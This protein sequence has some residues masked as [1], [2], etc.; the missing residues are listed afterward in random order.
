MNQMFL[1]DTFQ[2][3]FGTGVVPDTFRIN[4]RYRS[5]Q[6]DAQAGGTGTKND[7]LGPGQ[8][9]FLEPAFEKIPRRLAGGAGTAFRII[10]CH[11]Q[12]NMP[13]DFMDA[14]SFRRR[15][16]IVQFVVHG[17][18]SFRRLL[19]QTLV[20]R[21]GWR[22][23]MLLF[24]LAGAGGGEAKADG[25]QFLEP[26]QQLAGLLRGQSLPVTFTVTNPTDQSITVQATAAACACTTLQQAPTNIPPHGLGQ[27]AWLYDSTG[28]TGAVSQTV[29][30][31]I[32]GGPVLT[33]LFSTEVRTTVPGGNFHVWPRPHG[34]YIHDPSTIVKCNNEH[35]LFSTG[36]GIP[37]HHSPT[38]TNWLSGP[39]VFL[40]PPAWTAQAVPGN[41]G[42]FWAP[43]IIHVGNR[44]LLY[45]AVSTW[46]KRVSAIGLATTPTL[47]P[48]DQRYHWTDAGCVI[49]ST[50]QDDFNTIDPSV[51]RDHDGSL[52]L[53]FGS[54]WTGIKLIQ[55]DPQTGRRLSPDSPIYPLACRQADG[56]TSMEAACLTRQGEWYY[57]FANWGACCRGMTSTYEI[58]IGR[59]H[60]ITGPYFDRTGRNLLANGGDLFLAREGRYIGPGHAGIYTEQGTNWFSFHYYDGERHGLASVGVR[61][62]EWNSAGWPVLGGFAR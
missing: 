18:K 44:Y 50:Q 15:S 33:G 22:Q 52:W 42:N 47:D 19:S 60:Q 26:D 12:K 11:T 1:N 45:Y 27:F 34:A 43:D 38:L 17:F 46:G 49:R 56:D 32:L 28:A 61:Q 21:P 16:E 9:E 55:L 6:T 25:I 4:H 3:G 35:W 13:P 57:L 30:V 62:L 40:R 23:A 41:D 8:V 37:S 10:P 51:F 54:F 59:S 31:Q 48:A 5:A 39:R 58:R 7:R 20:S 14:Q 29:S 36:L 24:F 53:A 2:H